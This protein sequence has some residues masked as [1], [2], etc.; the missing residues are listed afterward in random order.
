MKKELALKN[1]VKLGDS[2][3]DTQIDGFVTE[4][5]YDTTQY[6]RVNLL[7]SVKE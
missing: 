5:D 7:Q 4:V 6:R 3:L 2:G 1:A